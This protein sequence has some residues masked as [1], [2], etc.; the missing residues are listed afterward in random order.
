MLKNTGSGSSSL[1]KS[2]LHS[3]AVLPSGTC[4]TD[5]INAKIRRW[6]LPISRKLHWYSFHSEFIG[7][8]TARYQWKLFPKN[9]PIGCCCSHATHA[10]MRPSSVMSLPAVSGLHKLWPLL[11]TFPII[12]A[13]KVSVFLQLETNLQTLVRPIRVYKIMRDIYGETCWLIFSGSYA[14]FYDGAA[15][16]QYFRSDP[17]RL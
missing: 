17:V 3:G 4:A 6:Y 8:R 9:T 15:S 1:H 16:H 10:W 12:Q 13:L 7:P 5:P 2:P 11:L 14:K